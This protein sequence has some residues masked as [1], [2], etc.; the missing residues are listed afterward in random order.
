M[1][2]FSRGKV[3]DED[4]KCITST[5]LQKLHENPKIEE[6]EK[7]LSKVPRVTYTEFENALGCDMGKRPQEQV[8]K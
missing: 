7:Q 3:C 1:I 6:N 5:K 2:I 4:K 8:E